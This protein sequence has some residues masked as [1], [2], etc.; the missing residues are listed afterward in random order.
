MRLS[1]FIQVGPKTN[2]KCPSKGT[3]M[4]NR[5]RPRDN[6][7]RKGLVMQPQSKKCQEP[8]QAGRGWEGR[9]DCPWSPQGSVE[10]CTL[11]Q[12][13][14]LPTVGEKQ[15]LRGGSTKVGPGRRK[16]PG[17]E[18]SWWWRTMKKCQPLH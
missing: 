4:E 12:T 11:T 3:P 6:G 10:P 1:C 15:L 13:S 14:V 2:D 8:P 5:R 7:S 17:G 18:T 9:K 16:T